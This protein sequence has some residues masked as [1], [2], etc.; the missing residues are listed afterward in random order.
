ML[1]GWLIVN[2]FLNTAKFREIYVWLAE[3]AKKQQ[4]RLTF[5]TNADF[6]VRADTGELITKAF[7]E[8]QPD[9]VLFWDKDIRLARALEKKG[10]RLFNRADAIEACDDKSLCAVKLAG[11]VKMPR[12]Y[13]VPM[14]YSNIGYTDFAFLTDIEKELSYPYIIKEC[15]GSF[16]MQ[17]Y[18]AHTRTEAA[19]LLSKNNKGTPYI[20]QEYIS[21]STGRDVRLHV[22]GN[23]VVTAMLRYNENDF[24]ANITNGGS[25]KPYRPTSEQIRLS[26]QVCSELQLDFAGVDILFG[27]DEEPLLCE[28]NS[29][30]HFKNIYDCTGINI[31][32]A[33]MKHIRT[34]CQ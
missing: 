5:M 27:P 31:A 12:T 34:V 33:I 20:F 24:R 13:V 29:N 26:L 2:R 18:L 23:K 28:V 22:V 16:G 11:I 15:F 17:V 7:S 9:F 6:L 32:D 4:I 10:L 30:A 1:N 8:Q 14:T 19:E 25:M 21:T 3:S